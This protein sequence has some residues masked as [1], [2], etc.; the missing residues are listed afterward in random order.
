MN[1]V[2]WA[3]IAVALL[4]VIVAIFIVRGIEEKQLGK[5]PMYIALM[6][7]A[8]FFEICSF[9][10]QIAENSNVEGA[11][12][13]IRPTFLV[14]ATVGILC[15]IPGECDILKKTIENTQNTQLRSHNTPTVH[16][17]LIQLCGHFIPIFFYIVWQLQVAVHNSDVGTAKKR[18]DA[19]MV[20]GV[21]STCLFLCAIWW[22]YSTYTSAHKKKSPV[23]ESQS[24]DNNLL[25]MSQ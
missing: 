4:G 22:S 12:D 23:G 19:C 3:L 6:T 25:L 2:D 20:T 14:F 9:F 8:M 5:H 10:P 24:Q 16:L 21:I 1:P 11:T 15:R 7:L 17:I 18:K 13:D